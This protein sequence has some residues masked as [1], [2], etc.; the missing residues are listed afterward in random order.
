MLPAE[1]VGDE[2]HL[3]EPRVDTLAGPGGPKL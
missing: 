3:P 1:E 2:N